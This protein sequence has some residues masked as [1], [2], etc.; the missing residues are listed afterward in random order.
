MS[1][2]RSLEKEEIEFVRS[3][4]EQIYTDF[5]NLVAEGRELTPQRVDEIAQGRVWSGLDAVKIGLADEKGGLI[6][7][8]NSAAAFS[9]LETYR[10][11]QYP[12][13][14]SAVDKLMEI[15]DKS[16]SGAKAISNP[17]YLIERA[18][19]SL[20]E[21]RGIKHYARLPYNIWFN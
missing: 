20:R 2:F 15:L 19:E 9:G 10:L 11:V 21:E 14:K 18:Y 5:I 6:D 13:K 7:A 17:A 3:A 16:S 12:I 1:G 4:I 8:I